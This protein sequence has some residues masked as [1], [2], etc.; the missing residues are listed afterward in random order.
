[1]HMY[2]YINSGQSAGR[3][4]FHLRLHERKSLEW[5]CWCRTAQ[6]KPRQKFSKVSLLPYLPYKTSINTIFVRISI[7]TATCTTRCL[8]I[9]FLRTLQSLGHLLCRIRLGLIFW[10]IV[11]GECQIPTLELK[12]NTLSTSGANN[13][14]HL[15][16]R[17]KVYTFLKS[18]LYSHYRNT[19][20][21]SVYKCTVDYCTPSLLSHWG[22]HISQMS[23]FSTLYKYTYAILL[24]V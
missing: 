14:R 20:M 3:R 8:S 1:M 24:W 2:I 19:R 9:E 22:I 18:Q 5:A 13:A 7:C 23:A 17:T 15:Y 16:C 4:I 11:P 12:P 21:I 10:E 6:E